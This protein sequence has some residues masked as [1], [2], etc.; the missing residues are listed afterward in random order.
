MYKNDDDFFNFLFVTMYR[1]Y[2]QNY[3]QRIERSWFFDKRDQPIL[4]WIL[5]IFIDGS[6]K[7]RM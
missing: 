2:W 5:G 7:I 3:V 4:K 6:N 1:K